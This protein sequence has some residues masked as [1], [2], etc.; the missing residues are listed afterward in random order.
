M[1]KIQYV[2]LY[3]HFLLFEPSLVKHTLTYP[4]KKK[5][6]LYI[7]SLSTMQSGVPS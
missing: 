5:G 1:S 2:R 7:N 4:S 3:H 6:S